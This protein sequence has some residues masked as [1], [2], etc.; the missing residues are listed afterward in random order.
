MPC[1][2][3]VVSQHALQQGGACSGGSA[4]GGS[5]PRGGLLWGVSAPRGGVET[6]PPEADSNCY[7]WYASYWNA[8]LLSNYISIKFYFR[9]QSV[10]NW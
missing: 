5:T 2:G 7:G 3:G 6:P 1:S 4:L 8:F 9:I 10:M